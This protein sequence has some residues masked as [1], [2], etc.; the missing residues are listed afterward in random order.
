MRKQGIPEEG[1]GRNL[2]RFIDLRLLPDFIHPNTGLTARDG[3][4]DN[5]KNEERV[6]PDRRTIGSIYVPILFDS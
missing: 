3:E 6:E 4:H 5:Q 1:L 2:P